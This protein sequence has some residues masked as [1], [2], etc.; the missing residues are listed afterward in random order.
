M[1]TVRICYKTALGGGRVFE[2]SFTG[3]QEQIDAE[4]ERMLS[5]PDVTGAWVQP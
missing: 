2:H 4:V 5:L 1:K 3:T